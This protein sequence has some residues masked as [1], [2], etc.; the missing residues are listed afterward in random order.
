MSANHK[1]CEQSE[2]I[3]AFLTEAREMLDEVEPLLID[4]EKRSQESSN[5]DSE[6]I[7]TI[8]RL[9]HS[10]KGAAGFLDLATVGKVSHE[11]ETLL[12]LFR[13]GKADLSSEHIDLLN[14]TT[15]FIRTLL[16][17]IEKQMNDTGFDG[18]A[19]E[20]ISVLKKE[21]NS[22]KSG[23][24]DQQP[25]LDTKPVQESKPA[26]PSINEM[27]SPEDL[28][29]EISPDIINQFQS[30]AEE[31][32]KI[33]EDALISHEK[34]PNNVEF[35]SQAFRA[36]H[37]LKGNAGF[38]G[39]SDIEQLSHQSETVLDLIRGQRGVSDNETL[40]LLLDVIDFIRGGVKD[41][42]LGKQ[43]DI[44]GTPGLV[45]LLNEAAAKYEIVEEAAQPET[46]EAPI[47]TPQNKSNDNPGKIDHSI[48]KSQSLSS[49]PN[50]ISLDVGPM[51]ETALL[52]GHGL[53]QESDIDRRSGE[54]RRIGGRRETDKATS[55]NQTIRVDVEKLDMLMDLV[56]ELVISEALVSQN[57]DL[58]G[59]NISL[60]R[61]EKSSAQLNK[62]TRDLQDIA[63]SIRMISLLGTFRKMIRLTRD[64]S[65]KC[66]KKIDLKIIGEETEVD[67]TVI[68]QI[69]DPLVH[70]IRN[71]IDHGLETPEERESMGKP[72]VGCVTLEAKY[73]GGEVWISITDDGKGLD[74]EKILSKAREQGLI[75]GDG[76]DLQDD[77]VWQIIFHQGTL[78]AA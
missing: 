1:D 65:Q 47:S 45:S 21:I 44:P 36:L 52:D 38:L 50:A 74:R 30:E 51:G 7:N 60:D 55:A 62:I 61:F 66:A 27:G 29:L 25:L 16:D 9:F 12:D 41:I 73:A 23:K 34:E 20:L 6:V 42:G 71:C 14:R 77:D 53:Q 4:L 37:S 75:S 33:A 31:L 54:D 39:Y 57:P 46:S 43:P 72:P 22:L 63:M 35:I 48:N 19:G 56:G 40:T 8:F 18:E 76:L 26:L 10:L 68:E 70:I 17:S 49:K 5:V 28:H 3:D 24:H 32:L 64:L 78:I 2:F 58:K 15:D 69:N 67:K 11:A 13:K 59:L